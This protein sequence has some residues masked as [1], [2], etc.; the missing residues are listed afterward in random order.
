MRIRSRLTAGLAAVLATASLAAEAAQIRY[1]P[2]TGDN[3]ADIFIS[4]KFVEG[5]AARFDT[6][7]KSM[8][9]KAATVFL[10]GPG[11]LLMEGLMIGQSIRAH[12]FPTGILGTCASTCSLVWL[13][14]TY[15]TMGNNGRIG[16]HAAYIGAAAEGHE[17]GIANAMIGAYLT[18]L[19]LSYDAVAFVTAAP[20]NGITWLTAANAKRVGIEYTFI[21]AA[22]PGPPP[23]VA[24]TPV[25]TVQSPAQAAAALTPALQTATCDHSGQTARD[26]SRCGNRAADRRAGGR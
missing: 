14:G 5:D 13:S 25:A 8:P 6:I 16:F 4:G 26:G 23:V 10:S 15:R 9:E 7:V 19:G 18:R 21:P 2:N 11:G 17:S 20:P 12:Q 3:L 24:S 1:Q 22:A